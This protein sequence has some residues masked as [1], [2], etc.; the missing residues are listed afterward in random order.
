MKYRY[1]TC[2]LLLT[3]LGLSAQQILVTP[4]PPHMGEKHS[5][6]AIAPSK[7]DVGTLKGSTYYTETFDANLNGWTIVSGIGNLDWAWTNT[8]PGPTSSTYPVP[9]LNTSTPSGWAIID[10]D[11]LGQAGI[12]SESS[13]VSPVIDLSSAPPNLKVEFDQYFQE[14]SDPDVETWVGVSTDGGLTW[15]EVIINE[16]VG[17][18]GRPN[19][20]LMDVNISSWVAVNPSNV[21]LRFRYL[22]TWDYGW[23]VDNITITDLANNDMAL[24]ENY[25]TDFNFGSTG[26]YNIE[27]SEYPLEQAREVIPGGRTKNKGFLDQ[28]SVSLGIAVT[29]PGGTTNLSSTPYDATPGQIDSVRTGGYTPSALGTYTFD[30]TVAQNETDELPLNNTGTS[31]FDVVE[32]VWAQDDGELESTVEAAGANEEEQ[33]EL[34]NYFDVANAGSTIYGIAVAIEEST[35]P[36]TLIYGIVRDIDDSQIGGT[37]DDYEVQASDLSGTG[38]SNWIVLELED[39]IPL[40]AGTAYLVAVGSY[41]GADQVHFGTSGNSAAQ[42][43]LINYP[44]IAAPTFFYVT[45]TPMVRALLSETCMGVGINEANADLG[46]VSAWPNPFAQDAHIAFQLANANSVS[47]EVRDMTGRVVLAEDLGKLGAGQHEHIIHGDALASG[48]YTWTLAADGIRRSGVIA[49]N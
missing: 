8:G 47:L 45:K 16:G 6:N 18:D 2:A 41:G 19:P 39:P 3:S 23:Q 14:F 17:R 4:R 7:G 38:E 27:Y 1:A 33:V 22:A 44:N 49:K 43:S 36:G 30:Y 20:E 31:R 37:A 15:D 21:Q 29:G 48:A 13:L 32:C 42:V 25:P 5:G 9:V 34:G 28:T 46:T 26:L 24:L 12:Q 11:Y 40:D 35:A 10:D